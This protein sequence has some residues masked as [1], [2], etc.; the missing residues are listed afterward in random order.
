[1][2]GISPMFGAVGYPREHRLW[3][4][5]TGK[6]KPQLPRGHSQPLEPEHSTAPPRA[7]LD[8]DLLYREHQYSSEHPASPLLSSNMSCTPFLLVW[9]ISAYISGYISDPH[10]V[11][12]VCG[13]DMTANSHTVCA[14]ARKHPWL[15]T[16]SRAFLNN[17]LIH[18][19]CLQMVNR[20]SLKRN[21]ACWDYSQTP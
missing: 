19:Y 14:A 12:A 4:S 17:C 2:S 15:P 5:S 9:D 18:M 1:M 16:W 20:F 10:P 7:K 3:T 21:L 8:P 11:Q 13:Q 6:H